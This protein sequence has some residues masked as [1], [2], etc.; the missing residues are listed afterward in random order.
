MRRVILLLPVL[1]GLAACAAHGPRPED[2]RWFQPPYE[3]CYSLDCGD[4]GY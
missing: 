4:F 2:E 3:D 1:T